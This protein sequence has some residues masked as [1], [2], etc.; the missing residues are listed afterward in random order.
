E[1][2]VAD[3]RGDGVGGGEFHLLIDRAGAAG[4]GAAKNSWEAKHVIDLVRI[5]AASGCDHGHVRRGIFRHDLRRWVGHG[6]HDGTLGHL[7]HRFN[8]QN[9][10]NR[11]TQENIG[12]FDYVAKSSL[13]LIRISVFRVPL[14]DR[15]HMFLPAAIERA[16]LVA[17]DDV[18]YPS[19]H[20]DF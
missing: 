15:V 14:L 12:A 1:F 20:Y 5:V 17:A 19:V 3:D 11:E 6:K 16:M 13:L 18:S 2:V 9:P 10:G 7:L 8:S 4:E